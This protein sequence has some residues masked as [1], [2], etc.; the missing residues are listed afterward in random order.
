MDVKVQ[1]QHQ[2]LSKLMYNS[3]IL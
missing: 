3:L 2:F 1:E